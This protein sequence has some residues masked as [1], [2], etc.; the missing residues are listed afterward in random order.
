[1]RFFLSLILLSASTVLIGQSN[2]IKGFVVDNETYQGLSLV[3][4]FTSYNKGEVTSQK[5]YYEIEVELQDTLVFSRVNYETK[6]IAI[7]DLRE[8]SEVIIALENRTLQLDSIVIL[9]EYTHE[10]ILNL[11][12]AIENLFQT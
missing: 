9:P 8:K 3:H 6:R 2:L 10:T 12:Y 5:G 1:M 11:K 7:M 4:V